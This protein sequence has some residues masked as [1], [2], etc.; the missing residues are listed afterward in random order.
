M[1]YFDEYSAAN[2]VIKRKIERIEQL[3][4]E[5]ELLKQKIQKMENEHPHY[6]LIDFTILR[7]KLETLDPDSPLS[8]KDALTILDLLTFVDRDT[9]HWDFCEGFREQHE[10]MLM[11][12]QWGLKK[13]REFERE[14]KYLMR[15]EKDK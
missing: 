1:S 4:E 13:I 2:E 11:D 7:E 14:L 12:V 5:R 6:G 10:K 9:L 8:I 15:Q 3:E